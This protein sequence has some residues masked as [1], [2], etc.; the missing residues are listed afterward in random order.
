ML[1][2]ARQRVATLPTPARALNWRVA[3]ALLLLILLVAA[4][5]RIPYLT[6]APPGLNQDE[7]ANAWNAWCLLKTGTDQVGTPW[8]IFYTRAIGDNRSTLFLYLLL[9]FQALGGLNVWT[10]RLP[11]AV[12]GILTVLLLYWITARLF[13]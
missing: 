3:A 5:L 10:A 13:D 11:S 9:P 12:G 8:P 2:K 4:G 6:S 7:A 1:P